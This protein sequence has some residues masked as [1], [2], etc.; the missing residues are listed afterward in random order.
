MFW[1]IVLIIL[2]LIIH[3]MMKATTGVA[4]A[5]GKGWLMI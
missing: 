3:S 5:V 2:I 4:K 1:L